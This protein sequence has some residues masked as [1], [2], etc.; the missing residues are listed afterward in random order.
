VSDERPIELP[1]GV[2]L[3]TEERGPRDGRP[4]LLVAGL[5]MQLHSWPAELCDALAAEGLRVVRFDNRDAGRSSRSPQPPPGRRELLLRR[6]RPGRYDL[7]DLADDALGLL[8]A[9]DLAPAHVVGVSMGG[10]IGQTLAAR[11]PEAVRSLVSIVSSTGDRRV[12]QPAR[13]TVLRLLRRPAAS[14]D[15][16]V[17]RA[18]AFFRH[19]GS[20]GFPFDEERLRAEAGRAFDRGHDPAGTS[21]QLA[22]ILKSGDRTAELARIRVPTLVIH[23]D[24]DRMVHPSGGAAT[25]AAIP[26]ARLETIAGMGHDLPRETWPQLVRLIVAHVDSTQPR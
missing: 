9:L 5:G 11:H 12:G 4:L 8:H 7:G 1:S 3:C 21:R 19:I 26:G 22:A 14:R 23:G 6:I 2:T 16:A 24:R 18:V 13:S 20:H 17:E 10:M 25:A 15:E